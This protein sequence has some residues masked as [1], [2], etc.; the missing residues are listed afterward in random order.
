MVLRVVNSVVAAENSGNGA[1]AGAC[2]V[3]MDWHAQV[4]LQQLCDSVHVFGSDY[5]ASRTPAAASLLQGDMQ[6]WE[7]EPGLL[8]YR[9]QVVDQCDIRTSNLLHPSLKLVLLLDGC[10]QVR[11]GL[12]PWQLLDARE[13]PCALLVNLA[14]QDCFMR[15][16][17]T[18][19]PERKLVISCSQDW[20]QRKGLCTS[21]P[22]LDRHLAQ[23]LWQPS[24]RALA[25]AEQLHHAAQ[26]GVKA[27][28]LDKLAWQAK[29]LDLLHEGLVQAMQVLQAPLDVTPTQADDAAWAP[30]MKRSIQQAPRS[31]PLS[32]QMHQRLVALREWM[33]TAASDGLGLGEIARHGGM[34]VASLQRYFPAVAQGQSVSAFL[35]SQRLARACQALGCDGVS[36]AHAAEI[37]GYSSVT[38]FAKAFR[39]AYGCAPSQWRA[40]V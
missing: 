20:L 16:W 36:V 17:Q 18:G 4:T 15:Q 14:Q 30:A 2:K 13:A 21:L 33:A 12:G 19:R 31:R 7:L 28:A 38:H 24:P 10:A 26:S 6:V 34:S 27:G 32:V 37:A 29:V 35:R 9:T 8:V 39:D 23:C 1:A 5:I 40:R 22:W 11:Y 25:L 3:L